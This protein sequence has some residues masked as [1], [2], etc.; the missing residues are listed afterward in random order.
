MSEEMGIV[1]TWCNET[2]VLL[3]EFDVMEEKLQELNV[4]FKSGE[5][6]ETGEQEVKETKK[7][8]RARIKEEKAALRED[9]IEQIEKLSVSLKL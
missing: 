7:E 8:K 1:N 2:E 3:D 4:G 6:L 5:P 9:M